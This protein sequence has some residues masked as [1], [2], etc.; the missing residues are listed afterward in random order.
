LAKLYQS[1]A[2]MFKGGY[3]LDEALQV[4]QGLDLGPRIGAG[5]VT[6]RREIGRG[7]AAS[8]ALA[9]GGLTETV[10][11]RL[12]AVG[13]RTGGFAPVLL[14]DDS[15]ALFVAAEDPWDEPLLQRVA[16]RIGLQAS[17]AAVQR[18]VLQQWLGET[19][20]AGNGAGAAA[21]T[22][23][24]ADGPIVQFVDQALQSG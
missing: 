11:E 21:G 14:R 23:S 22:A 12:L 9:G 17:A 7:K 13:E 18:A 3:T 4:C 8:T 24:D 5:L 2:L 16:R 19:V 15:G 20:S 10:T 1:L 6:A